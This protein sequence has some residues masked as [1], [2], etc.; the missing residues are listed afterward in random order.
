MAITSAAVDSTA[1]TGSSGTTS[2]VTGVQFGTASTGRVLVGAF[3][4]DNVSEDPS[5]IT[6][7]GQTAVKTT[8]GSGF[9]L[10]SAVVASG[11]SGNEVGTFSSSD[12]LYSI[13]M[14]A[15]TGAASATPTDTIVAVSGNGGTI[16]VPAGGC[17]IAYAFATSS[18]SW[19]GATAA[20]TNTTL[21]PGNVFAVARFDNSG[22]A[23]T[24]RAISYSTGLVFMAAAFDASGGGGDTLF[25]GQ[26]LRIM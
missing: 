20:I 8:D 19:T 6:I 12:I 22:G 21:F 25:G 2:T 3:F 13:G 23:L 10:A 4:T 7:G 1:R 17:V 18:G 26:R 16:D 15:L 9:G 14:M 11:T 24:N 5:P